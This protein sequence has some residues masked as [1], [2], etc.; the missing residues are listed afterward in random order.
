MKQ[1]LKLT[2]AIEAE[3]ETAFEKVEKEE[4]KARE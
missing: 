4:R 3:R 2:K 1:K